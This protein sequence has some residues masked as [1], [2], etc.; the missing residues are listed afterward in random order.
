MTIG[1]LSSV[2]G[3]RSRH[4][5][6][7]MRMMR[8]TYPREKERKGGRTREEREREMERERGEN[9]PSVKRLFSGTRLGKAGFGHVFLSSGVC[10]EQKEGY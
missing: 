5:I 9:R 8:L 6:V 7:V 2:L 1:Q 4:C 10:V 3:R